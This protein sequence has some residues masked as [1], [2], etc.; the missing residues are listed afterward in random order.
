MQTPNLCFRWE[1]RS[2]PSPLSI[3]VCITACSLGVQ[4]AAAC[5][6]LQCRCGHRGRWG[7][8]LQ[9][10]G[11]LG[12]W[13]V[14][15]SVVMPCFRTKS[16]SKP[17]S[18]KTNWNPN[19]SDPHTAT[20]G[21]TPSEELWTTDSGRLSTW[22]VGCWF[23]VH[24]HLPEGSQWSCWRRN[25]LGCREILAWCLL[26]ILVACSLHVC[27]VVVISEMLFLF[28]F[29]DDSLLKIDRFNINCPVFTVLLVLHLMHLLI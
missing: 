6:W 3:C 15:N 12:K 25:R 20:G 23:L 13:S 27:A 18:A 2:S 1:G 4:G 10:V 21:F 9:E 11:A 8:W 28:Q 5:V 14:L 29:F 16:A 7:G 22:S 26:I 19:P 17:F 24:G